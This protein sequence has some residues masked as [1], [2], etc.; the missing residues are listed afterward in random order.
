MQKGQIL[1]WIIVGAM[2]IAAAGGAYFLGRSTSPKPP[3]TPTVVS[4]TPQPTPTPS[5][6]ET[7]NWKTL[8]SEELGFSIKYPNTW[9]IKPVPQSPTDPNPPREGIYMVTD[10]A[11]T[12]APESST[13]NPLPL[14][15][16]IGFNKKQNPNRVP[17]RELVT[18]GFSEKIKT[19][20][21][22][23]QEKMGP[24]AVYK[25]VDPMGYGGLGFYI[26]K[27]ETK[28]IVIVVG[29]YDKN[30]PSSKLDKVLM[31][32]NKMLSTF[33]FL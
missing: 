12:L 19:L 27:D 23:E 13:P 11:S 29:P 1:I 4:Q 5:A 9:S 22:F 33:K 3:T 10:Q 16:S 24:Y 28:Y 2:I 14:P 30:N 20:F 32:L 8:T 31:D 15:Y 21:T 17:I 7:A 6:D 25:I 26:T 18:E